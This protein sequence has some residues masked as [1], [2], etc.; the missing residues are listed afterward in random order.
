MEAT[1]FGRVGT[2]NSREVSVGGR[3]EKGHRFALVL[4]SGNHQRPIP[5][6]A[7]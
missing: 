7:A 3:L 2:E 4:A 5:S 1:L 6:D